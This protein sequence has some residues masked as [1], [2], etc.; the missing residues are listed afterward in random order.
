MSVDMDKVTEILIASG[1]KPSKPT[2]VS[3][4]EIAARRNQRM[5]KRL[6]KV[7]DRI[8]ERE[9]AK[10]AKQKAIREESAKKAAKKRKL[11]RLVSDAKETNKLIKQMKKQ[12]YSKARLRGIIKGIEVDRIINKSEA[13]T[14]YAASSRIRKIEWGND[15]PPAY[16]ATQAELD[17]RRVKR[18]NRAPDPLIEVRE[19]ITAKRVRENMNKPATR[20]WGMQSH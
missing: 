20:T 2:Y 12:H 8:E 19:R 9:R 11:K 10:A 5:G 15:N 3:D 14:R 16:I 7:A 17:A 1:L 13:P 6:M 18:K 4:E